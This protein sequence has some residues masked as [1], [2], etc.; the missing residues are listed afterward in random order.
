MTTTYSFKFVDDELNSKLLDLLSRSDVSYAINAGAIQYSSEDED[1][2]GN[3]LIPSIRGLKF[4]S[5]Q[6]VSCPRDWTERYQQYMVRHQ[7]PFT[8]EI[9]DGEVSFLIPAKYDPHSWKLDED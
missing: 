9:I 3:Q 8:K 2:V 7:V 1:V 6:V 4:P 5:W